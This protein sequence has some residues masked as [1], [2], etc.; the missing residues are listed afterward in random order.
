MTIDGERKRTLKTAKN[1]IL[2]PKDNAH[3]EAV[4]TSLFNTLIQNVSD[5]LRSPLFVIKSYSQLLQRNQDP[6]RLNRGF[7]LMETASVRMENTITQLVNLV[8]IYTADNVAKELHY[9]R[10]AY[11]KAS[12][13]LYEELKISDARID[14]DFIDHTKLWFN[15]PYLELIITELLSNAVIHNYDVENLAIEIKSY[16]IME[17]LVLEVKDN[18]VGFDLNGIEKK[19]K[20]PFN[21]QTQIPQCLGVG[22]SKVEAIAKVTGCIFEIESKPGIGTTCRFHFQ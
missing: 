3:L 2:I 1:K 20:D 8:E 17:R 9:F 22:L 13:N 18:G 19:I 6:E 14:F 4:N 7:A 15:G 11:D 16:K 10:E 21:N 5:K 12:M